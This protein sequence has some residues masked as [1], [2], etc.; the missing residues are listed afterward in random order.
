MHPYV[1]PT[2]E[3][4]VVGPTLQYAWWAQRCSTCGGPTLQYAWWSQRYSTCGGPNAAVRV[5]VPTVKARVVGPTLQHAWWALRLQYVWWGA[6]QVETTPHARP[7]LYVPSRCD[8][9]YAAGT[10]WSRRWY[11]S[12][13]VQFHPDG[14][15]FDFVWPSARTPHV[16]PQYV[17]CLTASRNQEKYPPEK[18]YH[19]FR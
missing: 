2:A 6:N 3:S 17:W 5:V 12:W 15:Q 4:R 8:V 13:A 19:S 14:G 18:H 7:G 9:A 16:G 10:G 11:E 1:V